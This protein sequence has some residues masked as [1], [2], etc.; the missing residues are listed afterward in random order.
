MDI[1]VL[2]DRS[3]I[4]VYLNKDGTQNENYATTFNF[5][6]PEYV[7]KDGNQIATADLNKYIVFDIDG[8]N[9]E[10][11]IID[12]KYSLKISVTQYKDIKACIYLKEHS[13]IDDMSDKLI[14]IS[15][16]F[17]IPLNPTILEK[18]PITTEKIDTFNTLYTE[19]NLAI[20]EVQDLQEYIE[21]FKADVEAGL[22]N[23]KS[24]E[25]N[26]QGTSL[27]IKREDE[28]EY[29][30]TDLKG[31]KGDCNFATFEINNNMELVMNKTE[32]MLLDFGLDEN[33]YLYVII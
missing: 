23:G 10:D 30:Y 17:T 21:Q 4:K 14:W 24:L 16:I 5:D 13:L 3:V 33:S 32:D 25:Y 2:E 12:N 9:N 31:E 22:Y 18:N 7:E 26:W 8:E 20:I 15:K 29:E 19:L 1:K 11:L 6:F 27:G 28:E